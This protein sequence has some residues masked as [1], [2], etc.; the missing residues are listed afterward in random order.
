MPRNFLI[1]S[2]TI[3]II[4]VLSLLTGLVVAN[5]VFIHNQPRE[6]EFLVPWLA[7]RT[8]L[9]YGDNGHR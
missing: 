3:S 6:K 7:A 2:V 8:F 4:I 9:Q 5:T 1:I